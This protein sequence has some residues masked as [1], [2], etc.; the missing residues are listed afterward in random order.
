MLEFFFFHINPTVY[1]DRKINL[2]YNDW[3][4]LITLGVTLNQ[5]I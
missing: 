3:E 5:Y 2:L 1:G 4:K